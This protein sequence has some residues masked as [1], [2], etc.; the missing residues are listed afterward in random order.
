MRGDFFFI[1]RK[2]LLLMFMIMLLPASP[3]YAFETQYVTLNDGNRMP[4]FGFGTWT[5]SDSQ[6]EELVYTATVKLD[7]I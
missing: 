3:V 1:M 6:A 2:I 7:V 5:L 4:V